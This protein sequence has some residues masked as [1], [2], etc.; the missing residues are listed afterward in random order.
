MKSRR[1]S[2][3]QPGQ[4]SIKEPLR[5]SCRKKDMCLALFTNRI[6]TEE[7]MMILIKLRKASVGGAEQ[8]EGKS[9]GNN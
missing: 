7:A 6:C 8:K 1:L 4:M 9:N 3:R 2:R 5:G